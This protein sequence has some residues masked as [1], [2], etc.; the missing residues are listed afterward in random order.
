MLLIIFVAGQIQLR[1]MP[2]DPFKRKSLEAKANGDNASVRPNHKTALSQSSRSSSPLPP[3]LIN[4]TQM[5]QMWENPSRVTP[6]TNRTGRRVPQWAYR[7]PI[8]HQVNKSAG[9]KSV[10]FVHVGKT[11]GSTLACYLGFYYDCGD[12]LLLPQSRLLHATDHLIHNWINDCRDDDDF[13]LFALRDP[14]ARIKSW[15][16]YER[17]YPQEIGTESYRLKKPLFIDCPFQTFSDLVE[18]GLS[19]PSTH[20]ITQVCHKRAMAAI[21]GTKRYARHNYYN[22]QYYRSQT[23]ENATILAIRTEHLEKDW[24]SAEKFLAAETNDRRVAHVEFPRF[25]PSRN[26]SEK[27]SDLSSV[28]MKKLCRVLC[29]EIKAYVDLLERAVNLTPEQVKKSL[30]MIRNSCPQQIKLASCQGEQNL[31]TD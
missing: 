16:T 18:K 27:D 24:V 8:L 5:W 13:Y 10:C 12:A 2:D 11:A 29:H 25:N 6:Y 23:P 26:V 19:T 9:E 28:G 3:L 31:V 17:P 1:H 4:E 20:N 14:I 21:R 22:F 30:K 15:F 7:Y